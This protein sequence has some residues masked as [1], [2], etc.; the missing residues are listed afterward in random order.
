[1]IDESEARRVAASARADLLAQVHAWEA[2][3]A[4]LQR[5]LDAAQLKAA[6]AKGAEQA[7]EHKREWALIDTTFAD[8]E[9][10]LTKS[11]YALIGVGYASGEGRARK[12][13]RAAISRP[14]PAASISRVPAL[15][16][17][18][19]G[20]S[21]L[22]L[23]EVSEAAEVLHELADPDADVIAGMVIDDTMSDEVET[24]VIA[25]GFDDREDR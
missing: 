2:E 20:G 12:S 21:D 11:D 8:V 24:I 13:A 23:R 9:W 25:A 4:E 19:S 10:L 7:R 3:R 14:L 6:K 22:D 1:V 5:D 16:M 18:I 15:I 17:R